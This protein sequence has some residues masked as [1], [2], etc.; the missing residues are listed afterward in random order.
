MFLLVMQ[1][2]ITAY[3]ERLG[4]LAETNQLQDPL[5]MQYYS[6]L[7]LLPLVQIMLLS[8]VQIMLGLLEVLSLPSGERISCKADPDRVVGPP[9]KFLK[10]AEA[11]SRGMRQTQ[12]ADA[13]GTRQ[14]AGEGSG[15]HKLSG[16]VRWKCC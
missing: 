16:N 7:D 11:K 9:K 5:S 14:S 1:T 12:E 13:R 10:L 8:L 15:Q 4:V 6:V 2:M 3:F